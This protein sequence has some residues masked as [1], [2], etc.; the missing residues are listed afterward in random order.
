MLLII[1]EIINNFNFEYLNKYIIKDC[2]HIQSALRSSRS[3]LYKRKI[4]LERVQ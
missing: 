3:Y 2:K 1:G 4:N